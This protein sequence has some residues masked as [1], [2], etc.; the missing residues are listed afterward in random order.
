[1]ALIDRASPGAQRR[2][3]SQT[4]LYGTQGSNNNT[5][6][7]VFNRTTATQKERTAHDLKKAL[8]GM[9]ATTT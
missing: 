5:G 2:P 1:V 9:A 4:N 7:G 8:L 6:N 3:T